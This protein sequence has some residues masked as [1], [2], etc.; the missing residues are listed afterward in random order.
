ML[1]LRRDLSM[2]KDMWDPMRANAGFA[3]NM[4]NQLKEG[5]TYEH[6]GWFKLIQGTLCRR[7]AV[8]VS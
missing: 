6:M 3:A 2:S 8:N 7:L 5:G 1:A 4:S